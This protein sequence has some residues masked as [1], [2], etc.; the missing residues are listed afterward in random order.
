MVKFKNA[1]SHWVR[2]TVINL[3]FALCDCLDGG[4][5]EVEIHFKDPPF[6]WTEGSIPLASENSGRTQ[7]SADKAHWNCLSWRPPCPRSWL[8]SWAAH[9][10]GLITVGVKPCPLAWAQDSSK[11]LCG[12][13]W[14]LSW[15]WAAAQHLP[16]QLD[17]FPSFRQWSQEHPFVS[18]HLRPCPAS[19]ICLRTHLG[20]G[21]DLGRCSQEGFEGVDAK[22]G[23]GS[24]LSPSATTKT[25][26]GVADGTQSP[27][28][29]VDPERAGWYNP[30][31]GSLA[32]G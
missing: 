11:A 8:H 5:M 12:V 20:G 17:S 6:S 21:S 27:R 16:P 22:T 14:D 9:T 26:L 31:S 7:P 32:S 24:W 1:T 29:E 13:C 19:E 4:V 25:A 15:G 28:H 30:H 18:L 23:L 2:V 3:V 10:H